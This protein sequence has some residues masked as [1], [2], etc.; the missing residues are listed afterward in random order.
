MALWCLLIVMMSLALADDST[1]EE[2]DVIEAVAPPSPRALLEEAVAYRR[3]GDFVG[4][5]EQLDRLDAT[6][7]LADHAAYH[8]AILHEVEERYDKAVETYAHV[9]AQW[10][11]SEVAADARFRRAYCLEELD[12]H[13]EALQAVRQ[14]QKSGEW[15]ESDTRT[16]ALQRGI[17]ELRSGKQRR[18]IRRIVR[19]LDQYGDSSDQ[20]WIRSK[21]RLALVRAQVGAAAAIRLVGDGKAARRLKQRDVQITAA[22]QQAIAMFKLGEPEF[23]LEGLLL[24]GDAYLTLYEDMLA[25]PPPR[26]ISPDNHD[27]YRAI[28][29][30]KAN[31]LRTK[32]YNRYDEGVRVAARTRWVGSVTQRLMNKRDE[33]A[34]AVVPH[35]TEVTPAVPDQSVD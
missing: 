19:T 8:R 3:I 35:R 33:L 30:R 26:S 31:I 6:G 25:Y 15:D 20:A 10:P 16:M 32:A 13:R 22:E 18:G 9:A 24:L 21:A 11:D 7:E 14:L 17:A 28:V 5:R 2:I 29:Q 23:A 12:R 34:P 27:A 1:P 4:S